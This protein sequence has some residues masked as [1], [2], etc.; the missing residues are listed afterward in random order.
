MRVVLFLSAMTC[1]AG[2]DGLVGP[3]KSS[4]RGLI[5]RHPLSTM[6]AG[7]WVDPNGCDHWIIDDGLEGFMSERIDADGLP[8]CSGIA[9]PNTVVGPFKV[10]GTINDTL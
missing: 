8:V 4:D 10:G 6:V 5:S 7:I 1:L 9:P 3:D 2:C